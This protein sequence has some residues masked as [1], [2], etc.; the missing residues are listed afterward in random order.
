MR[1]LVR[2]HFGTQIGFQHH[3]VGLIKASTPADELAYFDEYKI[4]PSP[5]F[6]QNINQSCDHQ[7]GAAVL[8][9][10]ASD[11][12][13]EMDSRCMPSIGLAALNV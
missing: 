6:L 3:H 5:D 8:D 12:R 13:D 4:A 7:T 11:N 2:F 1:I 9:E 10:A